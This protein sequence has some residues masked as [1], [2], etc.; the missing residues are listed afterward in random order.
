MHDAADS[1]RMVSATTGR[2]AD[3]VAGLG[4]RLDPLG[5]LQLV[6]PSEHLVTVAE[7]RSYLRRNLPGTIRDA[8]TGS[9]GPFTSDLAQGRYSQSVG[10]A[11]A[12]MIVPTCSAEKLGAVWRGAVAGAASEKS[13][14]E[15][16]IAALRSDAPHALIASADLTAAQ[17]AAM[18]AIA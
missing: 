10:R 9:F 2:V 15:A 8:T 7:A 3:S 12:W 11:A 4:T 6:H 16:A 18:V 13:G 1:L 5:S 14:I 17:A